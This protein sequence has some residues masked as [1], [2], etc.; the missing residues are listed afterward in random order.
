MLNSVQ[1]AA[2]GGILRQNDGLYHLSSA[3]KH[4][5]EV[6]G[7]EAE[8]LD[9]SLRRKCPAAHVRALPQTPHASK[10][11]SSEVPRTDKP[12]RTCSRTAGDGAA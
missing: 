10:R 11:S 9:L 1:V 5:G 4:R 8:F 6:E 12:A 3:A 7:G 2:L